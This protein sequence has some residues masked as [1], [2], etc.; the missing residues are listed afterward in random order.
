MQA[1]QVAGNG[2][3]LLSVDELPEGQ[4]ALQNGC[5]ATQVAE[6]QTAGKVCLNK[7]CVQARPRCTP[8]LCIAGRTSAC[9]IAHCMF[10]L[11]QEH[12]LELTAQVTVHDAL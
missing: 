3:V 9:A 4:A 2:R 5:E 6:C 12:I 10:E 8:P 11:R 1:A 7:T